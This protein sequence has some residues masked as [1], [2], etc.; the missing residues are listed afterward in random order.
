MAKKAARVLVKKTTSGLQ[1]VRRHAVPLSKKAVKTTH[2]KVMVRAAGGA[3][4][5]ARKTKRGAKIAHHHIATKPHN[6]LIQKQGRYSKWHE[7][8]Y[9]HHIHYGTVAAF[10]AIVL[11]FLGINIRNVLAA[12]DLTDTWNFT[13]GGA[14]TIDEGIVTIT[15][16]Q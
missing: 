7:W 3:V 14:Y 16:D 10:T 11:L 6:Q 15:M 12:S 5:V 4:L 1:S 13:T 8:R 9:H 2:K